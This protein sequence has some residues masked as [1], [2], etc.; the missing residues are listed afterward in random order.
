MNRINTPKNELAKIETQTGKFHQIFF[1]CSFF[2][3][4]SILALIASLNNPFQRLIN[5]I[6]PLSLPTSTLA[7]DLINEF[8]SKYFSFFALFFLSLLVLYFIGSFK[9][10]R[11]ILMLIQ[12]LDKK[13]SPTNFLLLRG[14]SLSAMPVVEL[15]NHIENNQDEFKLIS[16]IGGPA[17]IKGSVGD[18]L[19]LQTPDGNISISRITSQVP[20]LL[21]SYEKALGFFIISESTI[22]TSTHAIGSDGRKIFINRL[23]FSILPDTSL[24]YP[25]ILPDTNSP[26]SI[27]RSHYLN[28]AFKEVIIHGIKSLLLRYSSDEISEL[29]LQSNKFLQKKTPS[30]R[31]H[32]ITFYRK[33]FAP[34]IRN[35]R[36]SVKRPFFRNRT[37]SLLP[38]F[39]TPFARENNLNTQDHISFFDELTDL[40]RQSINSYFGMKIFD[41][42]IERIGEFVIDD[43]N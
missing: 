3:Y 16:S 27:Q 25:L 19:F 32:N 18:L 43:R 28:N 8:L 17:K 26:F 23:Q 7:E 21:K 2:I 33:I 12:N 41:L 6:P 37:R 29:F 14:F 40:C 31:K 10:V 9:L 4:W 13:G 11:D 36:Q 24:T 38:G 5:F 42:A 30:F 1:L 39:H 20:Y 34:Q 35:I 15:T 22:D